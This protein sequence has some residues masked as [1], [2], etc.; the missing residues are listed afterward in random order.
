[1]P[2]DSTQN[3]NQLTQSI[4]QN[5]DCLILNVLQLVMEYNALAK[6]CSPKRNCYSFDYTKSW[7][8]VSSAGCNSQMI[9]FVDANCNESLEQLAEKIGQD[10]DKLVEG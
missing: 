9:W 1:M 8:F 10:I 2:K 4:E 3:V 6:T 5:T 7:I